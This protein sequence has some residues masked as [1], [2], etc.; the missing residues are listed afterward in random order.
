M[1]SPPHPLLADA[2][3]LSGLLFRVADQARTDFAAVVSELS[4][5]PAQARALLFLEEPVSMKQLAA[6]LSC[7]ASNVTGIADRLGARDLA[8]RVVGGDR[9]VTMLALT[10][11][12]AIVRR[13]LVD[14]VAAGST[15]TAKLSERE[16]AT[17]RPLLLK[18][19]G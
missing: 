11:E 16:R 7:D 6:H 15:V 8:A 14:L 18:L 2:H 5:T 17:L 13:R 10:E 9:R 19:L 1:S 3:D 4:L 12:G